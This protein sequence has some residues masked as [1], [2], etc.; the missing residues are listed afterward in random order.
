ME[1]AILY[2]MTITMILINNYALTPPRG[3]FEILPVL[4]KGVVHEPEGKVGIF[5]P[6]NRMIN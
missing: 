3:M 4:P 2:I 6:L 1:T 5:K